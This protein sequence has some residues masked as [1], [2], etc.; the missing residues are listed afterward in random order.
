MEPNWEGVWRFFKHVEKTSPGQWKK[1]K[2]DFR[3]SW[4]QLQRMADKKGWVSESVLEVAMPLGSYLEHA[5]ADVAHLI[6]VVKG[7]HAEDAYSSPKK[8]GKLLT[9]VQKLLKKVK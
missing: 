5:I 1:M 7:E 9:A 4:I 8:S 2:G 3:D 6:D